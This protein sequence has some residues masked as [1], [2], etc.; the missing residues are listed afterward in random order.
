MT[1]KHGTTHSAPVKCFKKAF[2]T[3]SQPAVGMSPPPLHCS[4]SYLPSQY[5]VVASVRVTS[6]FRYYTSLWG[7]THNMSSEQQHHALHYG[8]WTS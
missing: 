6:L 5:T 3:S 7:V 2:S 4:L 8:V 1:L